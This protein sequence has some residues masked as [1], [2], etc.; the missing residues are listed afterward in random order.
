MKTMAGLALL[1]GFVSPALATTFKLECV[2]ADDRQTRLALIEVNTDAGTVQIYSESGRDWKAAVNVS[3][4]D[5]TISYVDH[6]FSESSEAT[7]VTINRVTG[8]YFAY[9]P[10]T[11]RKDGQCRKVP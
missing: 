11:A 10:H 8:K 2:S 3:I 5:S 1:V 4:A 9:T 7:A 6:G